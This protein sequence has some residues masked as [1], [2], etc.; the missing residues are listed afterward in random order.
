LPEIAL[1]PDQAPAAEQEVAFVEDQVSIEDALLAT[2]AGFATRDTVGT[3]GG[4]SGVLGPLQA[5]S[6]RR[7]RGARSNVFVRNMGIPIP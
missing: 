1:A 7:S 3:A 2:D 4:D 6:A 5:A